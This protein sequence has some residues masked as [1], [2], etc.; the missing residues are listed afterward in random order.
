[1]KYV[2]IINSSPLASQASLSAYHFANALLERKHQLLSIFFYQQGAYHG[3]KYTVLQQD[4][5]DVSHLWA[6]LSVAHCCPLHICS[7]AALRRGIIDA[8]A[9]AQYQLP[10]SI[11]QH[12]HTISLTEF[13]NLCETS[14]RM[15]NF[16]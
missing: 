11:N 2:I 13:F 15:I 6:A 14:D 10:S 8:D 12:Y 16:A 7:A 3:S 9:A 1:M 5:T 4:E